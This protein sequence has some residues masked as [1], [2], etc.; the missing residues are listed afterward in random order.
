MTPVSSRCT[1]NTRCSIYLIRKKTSKSNN[2]SVRA[3]LTEPLSISPARHMDYAILDSINFWTGYWRK[4]CWLVLIQIFIQ[5]YIVY[6][7]MY[8]GNSS[9]PS[10]ILLYISVKTGVRIHEAM[11]FSILCTNL[12]VSLSSLGQIKIKTILMNILTGQIV[13]CFIQENVSTYL[14]LTLSAC[15]YLSIPVSWLLTSS[16]FL[17]RYRWLV[18][19][20]TVQFS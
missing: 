1:N 4:M 6:F 15:L 17:R 3:S 20:I 16:W 9:E 12:A 10:E 14:I 8:E 2:S 19:W 5:L 11:L 7:K 13:R 18:T